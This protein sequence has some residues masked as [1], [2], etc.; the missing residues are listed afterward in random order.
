MI[1]HMTQGGTARFGV[2]HCGCLALLVACG[3]NQTVAGPG[4][5]GATHDAGA[6]LD[7]GPN[8]DAG[9]SHDA[10]PDAAQRDGGVTFQARLDG[11]QIVVDVLGGQSLHAQSCSGSTQVEKQTAS[12]QWASLQDDRYPSFNNP[13]YYLD[14]VFVRPEFNLGCDVVGC[15]S[16]PLQI[17]LGY[18]RQYVKTG[19]KPAPAGETTAKSPA[20]VVETR[21]FQGTLRITIKYSTGASCDATQQVVLQLVVPKDGVCCPIGLPGCS[22]S[23]PGGGWA[24]SLTECR[25]WSPEYDVYF[26]AVSDVHGCPALAADNAQC[27]GCVSDAGM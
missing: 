19:E 22:S 10:G 11:D 12:G 13:G 4:D 8:H 5:A 21:A 2:F 16:L 3:Q 9:P 6:R 26:A 27:C 15:D 20:P 14:G 23:G 7:A 1:T 17:F 18:A 25:T 24:R